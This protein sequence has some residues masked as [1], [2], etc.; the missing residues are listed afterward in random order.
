MSSNSPNLQNLPATGSRFA[1]LVKECFTSNNDWLMCG[2][3]F[4]SLT[5]GERY[6]N[7]T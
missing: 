4:F 5:L 2:I 1:K 6:S 7:V 3:D